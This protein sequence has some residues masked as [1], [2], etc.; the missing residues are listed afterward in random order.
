M[1]LAV[2]KAGAVPYIRLSVQCIAHF[3]FSRIMQGAF[4]CC[5]HCFSPGSMVWPLYPALALFLCD[6]REESASREHRH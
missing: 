4:I 6:L 2:P 3:R 5:K 1:L